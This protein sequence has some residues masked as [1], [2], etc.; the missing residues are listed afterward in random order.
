MTSGT[1][2]ATVPTEVPTIARVSGKTI[3]IRMRNGTERRRF[4]MTLRTCMSP[5]GRGRTP[6]FSPAT[7]STPRG[8]PIIT[9]N[10]VA[11]MVTYTVS[12]IASGNSVIRISHASSS[13]CDENILSNINSHLLDKNIRHTLKV[14]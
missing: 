14:V 12:H 5:L 10:S 3:I 4:M 1:M 9:A 7:S 13:V 8:S 6:F 11:M 2:D